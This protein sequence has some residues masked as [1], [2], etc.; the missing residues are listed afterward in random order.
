M[1]RDFESQFNEAVKKAAS[2]EY[3]RVRKELLEANQNEAAEILGHDMRHYQRLESGQGTANLSKHFS[4]IFVMLKYYATGLGKSV[5]NQGTNDEA[6]TADAYAER[7]AKSILSKLISPKG[8]E[9][10]SH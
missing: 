9:D 7:E 3:R 1:P 4:N 10:D 5:I 8:H 6:Q 2:E